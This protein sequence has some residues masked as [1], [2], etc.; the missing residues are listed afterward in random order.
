MTHTERLPECEEFQ[1]NIAKKVE[2]HIDESMTYR[3][4]SDTQAH[5]ILTLE[6]ANEVVMQ[7]IRDI[8]LDIKEINAAIANI[9]KNQET[10][11]RD[12]K[13]W[14]LGGMIAG[15]FSLTVSIICGLVWI[16]GIAKQVDIN[17]KR[18]ETQMEG[19][20]VH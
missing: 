16:G 3:S 19:R 7:D 15:I 8:K 1:C 18:W 9:E 17:T 20:M 14:I 12:V 13:I 11:M 6:K 5:Q 10:S 4:R 2:K